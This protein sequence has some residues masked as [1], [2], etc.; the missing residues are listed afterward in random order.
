[1]FSNQTIHLILTEIAENIEI[2]KQ[3]HKEAMDRFDSVEDCL[4]NDHKLLSLGDLYIY[5]QGSFRLGTVVCP[6]KKGAENNYDID[7]VCELDPINENISPRTIKKAVGDCLKQN[8]NLRKLLDQEGKRCWTIQY[9]EQDGIGFHLDVL[10]AVSDSTDDFPTAIATTTKKTRK[11]DWSLSDP[12]GYATWF[13]R[14]NQVHTSFPVHFYQ[15]LQTNSFLPHTENDCA[16]DRD[17]RTPLQQSIQI[18]KRHR[19]MTFN[20]TNKSDYPPI[21]II[22]TTLATQ[23][24]SGQNNLF[25]TL[26]DIVKKMHRVVEYLLDTMDGGAASGSDLI[27]YDASQKKWY[28]PN[29]IDEKENFADRWHEDNNARAF[30]F[31]KWVYALKRD[32]VDRVSEYQSAPDALHQHLATTLAIKGLCNAQAYIDRQN[33]YVAAPYY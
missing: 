14:G 23:L 7:L 21:S 31:F 20:N 10:S 13:H 33:T 29:P 28:I 4:K 2:P 27:Q 15:C 24:Y 12:E 1:M 8:H 32:L 6:I 16:V 19:D 26:T 11:Y 25:S 22:I 5:L 18:L 3:K 30:D 9:K 17:D